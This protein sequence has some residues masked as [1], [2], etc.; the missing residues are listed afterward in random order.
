M[1]TSSLK[2]TR[3]SEPEPVL[4]ALGAVAAV[5]ILASR[6][7]VLYIHVYITAEYV[8]YS[9]IFKSRLYATNK[10]WT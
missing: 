8:I 6:I 3:R 4:A 7:Y 2:L 5:V 10:I 1:C 9:A